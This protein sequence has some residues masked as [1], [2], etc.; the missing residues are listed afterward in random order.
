[1]TVLL[2]C[3]GILSA[4]QEYFFPPV[5]PWGEKQMHSLVPVDGN[6]EANNQTK[7]IQ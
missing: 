2:E 4:N 7:V 1:M 3:N 5:S 6:Q